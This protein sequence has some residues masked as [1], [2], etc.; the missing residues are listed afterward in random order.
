MKALKFTF[1]A[2]IVLIW[3]FLGYVILDRIGQEIDFVRAMGGLY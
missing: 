1:R 2:V 3:V